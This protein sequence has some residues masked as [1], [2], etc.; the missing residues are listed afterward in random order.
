[1]PKITKELWDQFARVLIKKYYSKEFEC[2]VIPKYNFE[3]EVTTLFEGYSTWRINEMKKAGMLFGYLYK[4]DDLTF[5]VALP[6]TFETVPKK[7][8]SL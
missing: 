7:K 5:L 4:Y 2:G 1:M 3:Q 8:D 6:G